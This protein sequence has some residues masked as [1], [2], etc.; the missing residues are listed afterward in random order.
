MNVVDRLHD[1]TIYKSNSS[2]WYPPTDEA[3]S[4]RV[5]DIKDLATS[6]FYCTYVLLYLPELE[7]GKFARLIDAW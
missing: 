6:M 1:S 5:W 4:L 7:E 3:I 2:S